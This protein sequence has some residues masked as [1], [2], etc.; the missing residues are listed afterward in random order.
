MDKKIIIITSALLT[1]AIIIIGFNS[2]YVAKNIS[3]TTKS[4]S[5][6][7]ITTALSSAIIS[8][9]SNKIY[10][11]KFNADGGSISNQINV[12]LN[13]DNNGKIGSYTIKHSATDRESK[14][15]DALFDREMKTTLVGKSLEEAS[16]ITR[17]SRATETTNAFKSAVK[18]IIEEL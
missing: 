4:S 18:L 9:T 10:D 7:I 17:V 11:Y 2:L 12:T 14:E 1:G 3:S 15:R 5:S 16:N 8:A 13:M 6:N